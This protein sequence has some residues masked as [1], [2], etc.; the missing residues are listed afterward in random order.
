MLKARTTFLVVFGILVGAPLGTSVATFVYADGFAYLS[1]KPTA[2]INC[3]VMQDQYNSWQASSHHHVA[4]CNDCHANGNIAQKYLQKGVN[5]FLHSFAFT[6]GY[7]HQPIRIN[8][9]DRHKTHV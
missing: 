8:F 6:T 4:V 7:F 2:C 9:V 3:H 1:S 5:G